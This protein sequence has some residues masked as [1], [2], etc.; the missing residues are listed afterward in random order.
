MAGRWRR[1]LAKDGWLA[2][3]IWWVQSPVD[4]FRSPRRDPSRSQRRVYVD[5]NGNV[6]DEPPN[7][8]GAEQEG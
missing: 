7:A 6:R 1:F 4:L 8:G 3:I 5:K 2:D